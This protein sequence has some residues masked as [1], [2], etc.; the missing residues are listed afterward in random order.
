[1]THALRDD[2]ARSMQAQTSQDVTDSVAT[3]VR[4]GRHITQRLAAE[5]Y[6]DLP[7]NGYALLA[8]LER[9]G[10]QRCS[11]LAAT[12]GL[13]PSVISRQLSALTGLGLIERR[14]DAADGRASLTSLSPL[15]SQA[16]AH[17]RALRGQ[18]A[19]EALAGWSETDARALVD[20]IRRLTADLQASAAPSHTT[21]T[22][23]TQGAP[24]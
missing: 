21:T 4:T 15:G 18:W 2:P 14:P 23:V 13:D 11:Q 16:L 7:A 20:L 22:I 17:T 5:L 3:L 24:Q 10:A 8:D 6:G 19:A 9:N 1:M 12:F